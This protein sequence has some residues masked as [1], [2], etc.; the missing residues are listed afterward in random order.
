MNLSNRSAN[1][2]QTVERSGMN[3]SPQS[4]SQ[5]QTSFHKQQPRRQSQSNKTQNNILV[6]FALFIGT[7]A[8]LYY[9]VDIENYKILQSLQF[10][11]YS[12]STQ[13]VNYEKLFENNMRDLQKK[14]NIDSDSILKLKSGK[15][16]LYITRLLRKI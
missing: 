1:N 10:S 13:T 16:S 8:I 11:S 7:I 4:F 15:L 2:T 3:W 14:Y 12:K 9:Y 6:I 5:Q